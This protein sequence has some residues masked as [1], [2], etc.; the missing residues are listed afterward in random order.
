MSRR[1]KIEAMLAT[2]PQDV[3]LRYALANE[4]ANEERFEDSLKLFAGLRSET[5]PHIPSFLRSAQVLV[6]VQRIDEARSVLREGIEVARAAG[7]SHPAG[8][9][10]ELLASLGRAGE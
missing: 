4:Y 10:G 8:E 7:E 3:F 9:M 1:E 2:D 6:G 5:P